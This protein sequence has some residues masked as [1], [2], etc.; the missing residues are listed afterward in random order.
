[1]R[2]LSTEVCAS[3]NPCFSKL[4]FRY[5]FGPRELLGRG[6]R[7][8]LSAIFKF[9]SPGK[10]EF[11]RDRVS[12]LQKVVLKDAIFSWRQD[13]GQTSMRREPSPEKK[14]GITLY[15]YTVLS[16]CHYRTITS[17]TLMYQ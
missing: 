12:N 5:V 2:V 16:F 9:V 14:S 15:R 6:G 8:D 17:R 11:A 1:M 7:P 10:K 13:F 4:T 3:Y